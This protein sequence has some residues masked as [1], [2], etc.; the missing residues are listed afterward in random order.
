MKIK[1]LAK[2]IKAV[3]QML[4]FVANKMEELDG[5]EDRYERFDQAYMALDDALNA[6]NEIKEI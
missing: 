1:N 5:H 4:E 3:D 2:T 6:L